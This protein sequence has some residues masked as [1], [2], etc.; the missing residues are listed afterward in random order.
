MTKNK[1]KHSTAHRLN[2]IVSSKTIVTPEGLPH[3]CRFVF[4]RSWKLIPLFPAN[5]IIR[6]NSPDE[7]Q[8]W[9]FFFALCQNHNHQNDFFNKIWYTP[10]SWGRKPEN[11]S[12]QII[13]VVF[14]EASA[15]SS[16]LASWQWANFHFSIYN[17]YNYSLSM[18]FHCNDIDKIIVCFLIVQ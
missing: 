7:V 1:I 2:W 11:I 9:C 16:F 12:S 17:F 3:W 18:V 4:S 15:S 14:A 13:S 5:I 10:H 8:A 6:L